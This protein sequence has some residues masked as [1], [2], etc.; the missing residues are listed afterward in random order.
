MC[1][2]SQHFVTVPRIST[3][4][5]TIH[6]NQA[7]RGVMCAG[8]P[9]KRLGLSCLLALTP[10]TPDR[11]HHWAGAGQE[12][13]GSR[14]D[15][16]C[17][18]IKGNSSTG[19]REAPLPACAAGGDASTNPRQ[20]YRARSRLKTHPHGSSPADGCGLPLHY[21]NMAEKLLFNMCTVNIGADLT[22]ANV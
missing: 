11:G 4:L 22:S 2:P 7:G 17:S 6:S 20:A 9:Q 12:V 5:T 10:S 15:G 14:E 21:R 3:D 8:H 18:R 19:Q 1:R 13:G 16:G